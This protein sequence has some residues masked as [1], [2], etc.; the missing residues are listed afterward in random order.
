M[1]KAG[2]LFGGM[3]GSSTDKLEDAADKFNRAGNSFKAAQRCELQR[4][5]CVLHTERAPSTFPHRE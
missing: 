5:K 1:K 3:L 4:G 2:G